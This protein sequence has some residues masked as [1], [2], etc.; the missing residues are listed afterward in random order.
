MWKIFG[1]YKLEI[2]SIQSVNW[3]TISAG[4]KPI[5][6]GQLIESWDTSTLQAGEYIIR[7]VVTLNDETVLPDCRV[8]ITILPPEQ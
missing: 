1:F 5:D 2:A 7:L 3:R 8:P 6:N 4:R